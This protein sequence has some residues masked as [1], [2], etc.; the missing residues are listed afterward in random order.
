MLQYFTAKKMHPLR[1]LEAK[2]YV[3]AFRG[4]ILNCH[5]LALCVYQL[6]EAGGVEEMPGWIVTVFA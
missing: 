2:D 5:N 4:R 6:M 3:I 1:N